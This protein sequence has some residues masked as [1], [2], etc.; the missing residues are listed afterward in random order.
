MNNIV[1]NKLIEV[2]KNK[3]IISYQELCNACDLKLNMRDNPSDR[4]EIGRILGEISVYEFENNRPLLSAVV[5]SK[6]GEE[7][8]GFYKLC[9]DLGL[10]KN[11]RKLKEEGIFSIQEI[12]KCHQYWAN[13]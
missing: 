11:W 10:T 13:N 3:S 4:G 6:N 8:D 2:S 12:I 5:L 9:E 1:R 7:G